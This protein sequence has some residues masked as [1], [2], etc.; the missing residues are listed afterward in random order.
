MHVPLEPTACHRREQF[1]PS[2]FLSFFFRTCERMRINLGR[3]HDNAGAAG[4]RGEGGQHVRVPAHVEERS[5]S[6]CCGCQMSD[7]RVRQQN[8]SVKVVCATRSIQAA[9]R[10]QVAGLPHEGGYRVTLVQ[11]S[12]KAGCKVADL[13]LT[14]SDRHTGIPYKIRHSRGE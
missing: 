4:V 7:Q 12:L 1:H 14:L 11:A 8:S 13:E 3:R 6:Q 10:V 9:H 2:F 5:I